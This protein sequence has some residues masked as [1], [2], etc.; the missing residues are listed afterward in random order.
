MI[1]L[2]RSAATIAGFG[3][4]SLCTFVAGCG[5]EPSYRMRWEVLTRDG[6]EVEPLPSGPDGAGV[7]NPNECT[8]VGVISVEV[9]IFDDLGFLADQ[10]NYPCFPR[11]F[12]SPSGTARGAVLS[13]GSYELVIRGVRRNGLGWTGVGADLDRN[14]D[15]IDEFNPTPRCRQRSGRLRTRLL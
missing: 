8:R 6:Q 4:L 5:S 1:S 9:S 3:A 10:R 14:D 11:E 2:F 15:G 13:D 12:H 7:Q